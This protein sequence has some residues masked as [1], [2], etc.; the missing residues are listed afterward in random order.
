MIFLATS[1]VNHSTYSLDFSVN[2]PVFGQSAHS[3][4]FCTDCES[5][6]RVFIYQKSTRVGASVVVAVPVPLQHRAHG[7]VLIVVRCGVVWCDDIAIVPWS[8]HQPDLVEPLMSLITT[9]GS[10][11]VSCAL[12]TLTLTLTSAALG[13]LLTLWLRLDNANICSFLLLNDAPA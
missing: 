12:L 10:T 1:S 6:G 8:R 4:L 5:L 7:L 11:I 3:G 13:S 9:L 2:S